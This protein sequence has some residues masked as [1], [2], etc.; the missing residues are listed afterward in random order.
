MLTVNEYAQLSA[1]T[2]DRT[3]INKITLPQDITEVHWQDDD[4]ETGFSAGVYKKGNQVVIAFTGTNEQLIKDFAVANVPAGLGLSSAQI[5]R[6]AELV[7]ETISK[8]PDAELSFT[9]HSL[10]GGLASLMAVFFDKKATV[11]D[12]APFKATAL[13]H[14]AIMVLH[15][16]LK[17]NN[18]RNQAFDD[19]VDPFLTSY[20]TR[21]QNVTAWHVGG[22][23]LQVLREIYLPIPNFGAI[24]GKDQEYEISVG[25]DF[26]YDIEWQELK[27][28]S[29]G[30]MYDKLKSSAG[31]AV[32]LHSMVLLLG[33]LSSESFRQ[34]VAELPDSLEVMFDTELYAVESPEYSDNEDIWA[35]LVKQQLGGIERQFGDPEGSGRVITAQPI[36]DAMARAFEQLATVLPA[37]GLARQAV[38]AQ[39][40]EWF[41]YQADGYQYQGR[42]FFATSAPEVLQYTLAAGEDY[43]GGVNTRSNGGLVSKNLSSKYTLPWL[44]DVLV[45]NG[46]QPQTVASGHFQQW[47]VAGG[48]QAVSMSAVN[49]QL[50]QFMLGSGGNDMLRGGNQDDLLLGGDGDDILAGSSGHNVLVGGK[51][52]DTYQIANGSQNVIVDADGSGYLE[53]NGLKLAGGKHLLG[54]NSW[55]DEA[56]YISYSLFG[57]TLLVNHHSTTSA[58]SVQIQ[59]W[60]AGMLGLNMGSSAPGSSYQYYVGDQRAKLIGVEIDLHVKPGESGYNTYKWSSTQRLPD[61][62]LSNGIT[63]AGF[64]DIIYG[65]ANNDHIEGR[66]GNDALDGG[67][68][69]DLIEGGAGRDLLLGGGGSDIIKGDEGDDFIIANTRLNTGLR[70]SPDDQWIMPVDG[71]E[72]V[73]AGSKWGVFIDEETENKEDVRIFSGSSETF[74]DEAGTQGD[75]LQGG[76]GDDYILGSNTNDFIDGDGADVNAAGDIVYASGNDTIYGGGGEDQ[77]IGGQ[78]DDNIFGDGIVKPG[79]LNTVAA[80]EHRRDTIYGGEGQDTISGDGGSDYIDGGDDNDKLYGDQRNYDS[81]YTEGKNFLHETYHGRD[82]IHGGAGNDQIVGGGKGDWL[83]GGSGN[84]N[85]WGDDSDKVR[86]KELAGDDFISGGAGEDYLDGGYGNDEIHGGTENDHIRGGAGLDSLYGDE[87]NDHITGDGSDT[88]TVDHG[89]DKL[90]GGAGDDE[91]IGGGQNDRLYGGDGDDKLWGD[92]SAALD[93]QDPDIKGQDYLAGGTGNDYMD[94]GMDD[95]MLYGGEGKD[96]LFGGAGSDLLYGEDGD[97]T[98]IGD[99]SS[100]TDVYDKKLSATEIHNDYLNGGNGDDSLVGGMGNDV[101]IGGAGNDLLWGDL[102]VEESQASAEIVGDDILYGGAGNDYLDGG[103][104]NDTL[105]GDEGDDTLYGNHGNDALYGGEGQDSLFGGSGDDMIFGGA[106]N[107]SL[108]GSTG[109]DYLNGQEGDDEYVYSN[110]DG[111]TTIEDIEG[112]T[113]IFVDSLEELTFST[114]ENGLLV[115]NN[116]LGDA[117]YLVGYYLDDA[118]K[119]LDAS[120][121]IFAEAG[122]QSLTLETLVSLKKIKKKGSSAAESLLGTSRDDEIEAFEGNDIL[123]GLEG[124]DKLLGWQGDDTYVFDENWGVDTIIDKDGTNSIIFTSLASTKATFYREGN[125]LL[126][127]GNINDNNYQNIVYVKD[128]FNDSS[129]NAS[130]SIQKIHFADGVVLDQAKAIQQFFVHSTMVDGLIQGTEDDDDIS[131]TAGSDTVMGNLGNDII[132]GG[133]GDDRLDGGSGADTFVFTGNWGQDIVTGSDGEDHMYFRDTPSSAVEFKRDGLDLLIIKKGTDEQIRIQGQFSSEVKYDSQ[134]IINWEFADGVVLKPNDVYLQLMNGT[135]GNDVI[136]GGADDD[137]I[138]GRDGND[139]LDGGSGVDTFVFTGNWGQD[140][141]TGSDGEDHMYFRDTPSSAVEFKRDGLDLLII[142]KGTDEQIRIQ[143]Q[144]SSEVK[145][146]SQVII[147]WEFADGV[148]LKPNNVYVQLMNGTDGN[149]VIVGG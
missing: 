5:T 72:L 114:Y 30:E 129:F 77:I 142:K 110:G 145:Y 73:F 46:V 115:T 98:L 87:G 144:F 131:G 15:I 45:A 62:S 123:N 107:D 36:L 71:K 103:Y 3:R 27:D 63:V 91:I 2:Y 67:A 23:M 130:N 128:Q 12:H 37:N 96:T 56:N 33:L 35:R 58:F 78:G 59:N 48:Q 120:N 26:L 99:L 64:D 134:V 90:Y 132:N 86:H 116:T 111:I 100:N 125:D 11:F 68:G 28:L 50:S 39:L 102:G 57:Q 101:L 42:P 109:K 4:P 49:E 53:W 149:D 84:D 104:G 66:L 106:G 79:Y 40:A 141:V 75:T 138:N 10:G 105:S 126:I 127:L 94:G 52:A 29:F 147:N 82:E 137:I 18:Y 34:S 20:E 133:A 19:Y 143:G 43:G 25:R 51:G 44:Q 7:L 95:D 108:A 14:E 61:G 55:Y 24:T 119:S 85:I 88:P 76:V 121:V 92:D 41:Y 38:I 112:K 118:Q 148:V 135:D 60:S 122:K 17:L 8:Y 9:G 13:S 70:V 22:E 97:D 113:I 93:N 32:N 74:A 81:A 1:R 6:S 83:Y 16:Y 65:S 117:I 47:N 54:N 139:R 31:K 140:I 89:I 80:Q 124:N 69:N 146:D 21:K 136:V